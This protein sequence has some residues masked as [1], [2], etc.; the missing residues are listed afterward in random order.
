MEMN[1]A[2]WAFRP[3]LTRAI[4]STVLL[5]SN[6]AVPAGSLP[7]KSLNA[8]EMSCRSAQREPSTLT[9]ANTCNGDGAVKK[10]KQ[11]RRHLAPLEFPTRSDAGEVYAYEIRILQGFGVGISIY[12]RQA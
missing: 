4:V 12:S 1:F 6:L 2:S 7:G 8:E 5:N 9:N 11:E 10:Q 3:R